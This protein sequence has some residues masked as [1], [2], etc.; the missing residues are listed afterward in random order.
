MIHHDQVGFIQG[1]KDGSIYA[2][3]QVQYSTQ[4]ELRTKATDSTQ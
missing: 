1:Y 2:N 3:Q 4:T